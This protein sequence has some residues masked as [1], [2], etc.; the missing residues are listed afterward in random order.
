MTRG[1]IVRSRVQTGRPY[2]DTVGWANV[3]N[4]LGAVRQSIASHSDR[5]NE[6]VQTNQIIRIP[7]CCRL[8]SCCS[9]NIELGLENSK[10]PVQQ[11][12]RAESC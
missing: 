7:H 6:Q 2:Y 5:C 10:N 8:V 4:W 9:M 1:R 3:R 12:F 11:G